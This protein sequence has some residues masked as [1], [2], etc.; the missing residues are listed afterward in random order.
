MVLIVLDLLGICVI[1]ASG[2]VL[3]HF[4]AFERRPAALVLPFI[5]VLIL[6]GFMCCWPVYARGLDL[7]MFGD[8]YLPYLIVPGIHIYGPADYIAKGLYPLCKSLFG[9]YYASVLVVVVIPGIAGLL[10]GSCQWLLI[11]AVVDRLRRVGHDR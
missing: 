7:A 2:W 4:Q 5:H 9:N 1:A 3:F 10:L 11:G 6:G 8:V